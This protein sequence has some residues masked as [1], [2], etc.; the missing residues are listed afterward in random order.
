MKLRTYC[1]TATVLLL[2]LAQLAAASL[3]E[4]LERIL[5]E[6]RFLS[7]LVGVKVAALPG[8]RAV[9]E[10]RADRLFQPASNAKLFTAA[11]V[12]DRIDLDSR[13]QTSAYG[14]ADTDAS[15]RLAGDLIVYGRGDPSFS[16]GFHRGDVRAPFREFAKALHRAGL[17]RVSGDLVA[18]ESYFN[19]PPLGPGWTWDELEE[20]YA[21]EVSAL[22]ALD[23]VARLTV[24]PGTPG[25]AVIVK[26]RP[27]GLPLEIVNRAITGRSGV[28]RSLEFY[29]PLHGDRLTV[30][31]VMPADDRGLV[32]EL[33][34][35]RPAAWF[36]ELLRVELE[37]LG[38]RIDGR[39]RA[40]NW[41][42]RLMEPRDNAGLRHIASVSSPPIGRL[43]EVMMK[44]SQNLYAQLLLL[45]AGSRHPRA[46]MATDAAGLAELDDFLR[47]SGIDPGHV[48]LEEGSGLSRRSLVTP[49]AVVR[50]LVTM[51]AH[52]RADAFRRLLPLAGVDGTLADRFKG[53]PAFRKLRAKTGSLNNVQALS[54]YVDDSAGRRYAFSILMNN[55]LQSG[56]SARAAVDA[57]AVELAR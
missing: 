46:N 12:L 35:R 54:G 39:V 32:R 4:R 24:A 40:V 21:A 53:T 20:S 8:G 17:R 43:T 56:A 11:L 7:T 41:H 10:N 37:E 47:A 19:A 49:D 6:P 33:T 52:A 18:D 25:G 5:S 29:R 27:G 44:E 51:D 45:Q 31:G 15:G 22:S 55:H 23:N 38:I 26:T 14:T 9:F 34:I 48:R 36:G 42:E 1:L 28:G 50:L 3:P 30:T 57:L 13:V 16:P 2:P